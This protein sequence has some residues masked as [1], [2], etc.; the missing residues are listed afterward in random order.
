MQKFRTAARNISSGSKKVTGPYLSFNRVPAGYASYAA[1]VPIIVAVELR[2]KEKL[3]S[4]ETL[5][6]TLVFFYS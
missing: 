3:A 6:W 2:I 1:F 4:V 5:S